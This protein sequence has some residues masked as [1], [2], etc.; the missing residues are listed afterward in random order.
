[1]RV[2]LTSLLVAAAIC[3]ASTAA[4]AQQGCRPPLKFAAGACVAACPAGY[5]D[6]G[7]T[8]VFRSYSR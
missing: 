3:S 1:M 8:C 7:S 5:E 4:L 6:R 2:A